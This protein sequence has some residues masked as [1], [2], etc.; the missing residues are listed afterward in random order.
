[1]VW[2]GGVHVD[3]THVGEVQRAL[4]QAYPTVTV[5]NVAQALET[6][7][8]V[9]IQITY[10]IQFLAAFSDLCRGHYSGELDCGDT[11]SADS[12]G[13]GAEDAGSYA[14]TDCYGVFDRVCGA[15]AGGGVVGI[16]LCQSDCAGAAEADDGGVS[17]SVDVDGGSAWWGLRL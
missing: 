9:V 2:Y 16:L 15:G 3:P 14:A 1:M 6:V 5:I 8:A 13:G 17:L 7:R 12:R 11:V 4:Y 10:V